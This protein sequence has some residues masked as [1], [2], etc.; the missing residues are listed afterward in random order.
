MG[1]PRYTQI[2]FKNPG[3][4]PSDPNPDGYPP[5]PPLRYVSGYPMPNTDLNR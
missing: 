4:Y 5:D 2:P 1:I 3:T